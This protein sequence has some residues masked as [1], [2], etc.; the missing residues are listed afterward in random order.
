MEFILL[1]T[2]AS[3]ISK[4]KHVFVQLTSHGKD[5]VMEGNHGNNLIKIII[6]NFVNLRLHYMAESAND[7]LRRKRLRKKLTKTIL[8]LGE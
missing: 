2:M 5:E 6:C 4:M 7:E 1:K 8:F 3:L